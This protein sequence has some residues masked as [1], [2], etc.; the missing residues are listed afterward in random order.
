MSENRYYLGSSPIELKTDEDY[1]RLIQRL[2]QYLEVRNLSVLIGNGCSISF[3]SP[4]I[5][6]VGSLTDEFAKTGYHLSDS[7]S[8]TTALTT[9]QVLLPKAGK[10]GTEQPLPVP[11]IFQRTSRCW[12]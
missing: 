10:F 2:R 9:L 6:D 7:A 4:L 3:G 1:G 12:A 8:Q 5:G 11:A